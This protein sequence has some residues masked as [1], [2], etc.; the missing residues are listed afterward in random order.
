MS[1]SDDD[2]DDMT[3]TIKNTRAPERVLPEYADLA[4]LLNASG[5]LPKAIIVDLDGT[6]ALLGERGPF[7]YDRCGE[8]ALNEIVAKVVDLFSD[9]ECAILIVTGRVERVRIKT[10]RWLH[11]HGVPCTCLIMRRDGDFRK[12]IE[13]KREMYELYI[14]DTFEVILAL[15]DRDQSVAGWRDLGIPCFQV[16]PGNF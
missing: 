12:D 5:K 14:R 6:L 3:A 13:V 2:D 11:R 16:A 10:I 8:D 9:D 7:D 4:K 1:D 15:D